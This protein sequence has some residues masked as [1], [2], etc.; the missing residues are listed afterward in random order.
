MLDK[1]N[2]DIDGHSVTVY[3]NWVEPGFFETMRIPMLLGR[4][5]FP[6]EKHVVI[7]SQSFARAQWPGKNPLGE[8]I[9]NGDTKDTVVGVVGN[10]HIN[11]MSDDDATEQYWPARTI[12]HGGYGSDKLEPLATPAA[13]RNK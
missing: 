2:R 5:F 1:E 12:R 6:G 11:A 10:A 3:P 9:G 7:V 8:Q 13:C 4:T